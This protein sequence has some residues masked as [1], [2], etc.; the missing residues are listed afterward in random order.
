M[1]YRA[2]AV[3]PSLLVCALLVWP[4]QLG[5]FGPSPAWGQTVEQKAG[6]RAA[7]E[8]GAEAFDEGRYQ[9]AIDLFSRAEAIVHAPPHLLHIARAYAKL[10][11]LVSAQDTY[12]KI[13]RERLAAEAPGPFREAWAAAERELGDLEPRIPQLT[14]K[15]E[16]AT[17]E[18]AR[19]TMDGQP[20]PNALLG[21]PHPADPGAHEI[22]VETTGGQRV[23][24]S[25]T[26]AAGD[27]ETVALTVAAV[28][29]SA[30][31]PPPAPQPTAAPPPEARSRSF[32]AQ[33]AVAY[34]A[35]G[36]GVV[37]LG[38]GTAYLVS[39]LGAKGDADSAFRACMPSCDAAQRSHVSELDS[40][41]AQRGTIATIA[42]VVGGAGV[43]GGVTLL[44]L[45]SR[46]KSESARGMA[47]YPYLAGSAVG[48]CG[49]Y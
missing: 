12:L 40:R 41:T 27:R 36:V 38:I 26:L 20:V 22:L 43:A 9:E 31:A 1:S 35:L 3:R 37:G 7:A 28:G 19:V 44:V 4:W 8:A 2:R 25:L 46:N 34:G 32:F 5:P 24:R 49:H 18:S 6:A 13:V 47:V 16:G 21:I 42:M 14:I 11:K 39:Y 29:P 15:V 48:L 45:G 30:E 10:G 23:I 17:S 33:P